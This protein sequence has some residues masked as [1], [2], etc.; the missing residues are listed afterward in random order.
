MSSLA[1]QRILITG[2]SGLVGS[3][4]SAE[5]AKLGAQPVAAVRRPVR[6]EARELYWNPDRGEIDRAKLEGIDAVVHLA[7]ENIAEGRWSEEFKRK[8]LESRVKG[9]HLVA[10]ALAHLE[11]KPRVFV[12]ASAI[13]YYGNRG[14]DVMT[15]Q[16]SPDDDFLAKV[17]QQWEAA[18]QPARDAGIPV[19][20]IRIGVVLSADGAALAK[21]LTPFKLG[22]GGKV[23][24]GEQ[25]MSW[26]TIDDLVGAIIFLLSRSEPVVGPVNV[27]APNPSTNLSFTKTLGRVLGRPTVLPMPA[28]AVKLLFGEMGDAL[29]LSSTRVAP[30]ALQSAGYQFQ[31]PELE[32]ALRHLLNR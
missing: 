14:A 11:R 8:I 21:M 26:I 19:T 4:L 1:N 17:C 24:S 29:L 22:L 10:D 25:F 12:S 15:E 9:T 13:G 3:R 27:V 31:Y 23:G 20:N 16:S 2:A 7:G 30:T 18:A 32:P 6:D 5:L 28:F